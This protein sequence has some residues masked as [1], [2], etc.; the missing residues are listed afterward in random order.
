MEDA[1]FCTIRLDH[2]EEGSLFGVF[3]GH[4]GAEV[5]QFCAKYLPK[6][7]VNS[8]YFQRA[9]YDEALMYVFHQMD[10]LLL[11]RVY[12]KEVS[13]VRSGSSGQ[14]VL[15]QP[16]FRRQLQT[17]DTG[18]RYCGADAGV[19][20]HCPACDLAEHTMHHWSASLKNILCWKCA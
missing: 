12:A 6:E 18:I 13:A 5:A 4:G 15:C 9:E 8:A 7:L 1:H 11:D 10:R 2:C 16:V 20:L 17:Q 19:W 14:L 3:D